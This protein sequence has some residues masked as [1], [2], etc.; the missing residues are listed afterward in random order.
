MASLRSRVY[1]LGV[2]NFYEPTY[3][4]FVDSLGG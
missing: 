4:I 3:A 2:A 1:A